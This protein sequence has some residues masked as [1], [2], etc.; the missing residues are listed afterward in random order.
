MTERILESPLFIHVNMEIQSHEIQNHFYI[1]TNC[2]EFSCTG[3]PCSH[4]NKSVLKESFCRSLPYFHTCLSHEIFNNIRPLG[5]K[6][7]WAKGA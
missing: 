2:Y 3:F 5:V 6:G 4:D 1:Y 7:A